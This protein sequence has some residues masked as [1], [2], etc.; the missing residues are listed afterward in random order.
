[1]FQ[2]PAVEVLMVVATD[3]DDGGTYCEC[4]SVDI[5]F[6]VLARSLEI[7]AIASQLSQMSHG[8]TATLPLRD[9]IKL[10]RIYIKEANFCKNKRC[11]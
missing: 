9:F 6:A 1:M 8:N 5:I 2:S 7:Y 3:I 10:S 4:L 11:Y